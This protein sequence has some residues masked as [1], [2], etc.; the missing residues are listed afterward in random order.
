MGSFKSVSMAMCACMGFRWAMTPL[1][2][3]NWCA[4]CDCRVN[5]VATELSNV[6]NDLYLLESLQ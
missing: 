1:Y 6:L 3:D 2:D 5:G 4:V